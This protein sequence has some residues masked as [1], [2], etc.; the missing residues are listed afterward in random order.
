MYTEESKCATCNAQVY[1]ISNDCASC[2]SGLVEE[3]VNQIGT[4]TL[5][6][7]CARHVQFSV[8]LPVTNKN[9]A[10]Q[11]S[12][13]STTAISSVATSGVLDVNNI[14]QSSGC[15]SSSSAVSFTTA[16]QSLSLLGNETDK[17][18]EFYFDLLLK[19]TSSSNNN[20]NNNN[21]YDCTSVLSSANCITQEK[22]I[23]SQ[24][25]LL[26]FDNN[27]NANPLICPI[28]SKFTETNKIIFV[29]DPNATTPCLPPSLLPSVS[30]V[31]VA[32]TSPCDAFPGKVCPAPN[33]ID[34]SKLELPPPPPPTPFPT[35]LVAIIVGSVV[36]GILLILL[37]MWIRKKVDIRIGG[38]SFVDV[39]KMKDAEAPKRRSRGFTLKGLDAGDLA[40]FNQ[41]LIEHGIEDE[42]MLNNKKNNNNNDNNNTD[43]ENLVRTNQNNGDDDDVD[44]L[45]FRK[46]NPNNTTSTNE[47]QAQTEKKKPRRKS[48]KKQQEDFF[49]PS[50]AAA[51]T[52]ATAVPATTTTSTTESEQDA[53][54]DEDDYFKESL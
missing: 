32:T 46:K 3:N 40:E 43:Q 22:K 28:G 21:N 13:K 35:T 39:S 9:V 53:F 45:L 20:N 2:G 5:V 50:A 47:D 10:T 24:T 54:F 36:G 4:R 8:V 44:D 19:S 49:K 52:T 14:V 26:L 31:V 6:C 23:F 48:M 41:R 38:A 30:Q 25:N 12:Q 29:P 1:N 17:Q 51:A 7:V 11:L 42:E 37:I 15:A 34:D 18:L 27:N 33:S 16:I